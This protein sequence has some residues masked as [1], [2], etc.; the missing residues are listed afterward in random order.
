[1][2]E[3]CVVRTLTSEAMWLL[4]LGVAVAICGCSEN[5][6]YPAFVRIVPPEDDICGIWVIDADRT[7][8]REV[9][10]RWKDGSMAPEEGYL[11]IRPDRRFTIEGLPDFSKSPRGAIDVP[12]RGNGSWW[13]KNNPGSEWAY[14]WLIFEDVTSDQSEAKRAAL[15]FSLEGDTYYL[16]VNIDDPDLGDYLVMRKAN[17]GEQVR[18][19]LRSRDEGEAAREGQ[20]Q[21]EIE[22]PGAAAGLSGSAG[23]R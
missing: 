8:W 5:V 13:A 17:A 23:W 7:T 9:R 14:L 2:R 1:M 3:S 6:Y 10:A 16:S 18:P 12:L 4:L 15:Y 22:T 21:S 20:E 19:R 11:E